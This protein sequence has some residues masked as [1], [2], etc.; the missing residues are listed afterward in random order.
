[1]PGLRG[2]L[3]LGAAG[4]VSATPEPVPLSRS[5]AEL[6]YQRGGEARGCLPTAPSELAQR[7][8]GRVDSKKQIGHTES[9]TCVRMKKGNN[10]LTEV[11]MRTGCPMHIVT[12]LP[13]QKQLGN[14]HSSRK[15]SS[16]VT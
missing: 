15:M 12:V 1:M 4:A 9:K 16:Y 11:K 14:G 13:R 6:T 3:R 8:Q 5:R 7:R 2:V 10:I